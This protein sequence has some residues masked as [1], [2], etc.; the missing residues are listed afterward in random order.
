MVEP[1]IP[2]R[3]VGARNLPSPFCVLEQDT[4][5]PG[6]TGNT[7]EAIWFIVSL[8]NVSFALKESKL[9]SFFISQ[10]Q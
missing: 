3:E 4:L 2:E 1:R 10:P 8:L 5:L 7:Q 6:S 9:F